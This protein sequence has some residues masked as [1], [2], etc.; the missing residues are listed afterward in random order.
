MNWWLFIAVLFG[1]QLFCLAVSSFVSKGLK[2][3]KDY[4][5]AGRTVRFFPLMMTLVATQVGG[6]L[7]LGA[8]Q[9]AYTYGWSVILY[10]LGQSLGFILLAAGIGRKM[11]ESGASTVA[12][13]CECA[14]G[15]R[16]LRQM[17]SILSIVS[18]FMIFVAQVIAS[19]KFMVSLGFDQL[20]IFLL[21]WA[22][23]IL[24]TVMGGLKAVIATD[25]VQAAFFIFVFIGALFFA[26]GGSFSDI[27][28]RST[29]V[30]FDA[31]PAPKMLGWL[32]MPLLFMAIEQD[33]GQRCF[34][35][36]SP[37]TVT[38]AAFAAA[39]VTIAICTIPVFF[40]VLAKTLDVP[41]EAGGS[42]FM[43]VI[44]T[45]TNPSIT[46]LVACAVLAAIISTADSLIN[47][48]SSNLTQDFNW[49]SNQGGG[50]IRTAQ[51][52]TTGI[53]LAGI[54]FSFYF[55]NIVD[56]LIQSY[57]LSIS[58]LFI[59]V[60]IALLKGRGSAIS[61]WISFSAGALAFFL[62]RIV[63]YEAPKE[64]ISIFFSGIGYLAGDWFFPK[65]KSKLG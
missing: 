37:K 16:K 43:T 40:G 50:N 15:S 26:E 42:V 13:L 24:Y 20:S 58:C 56:V 25:V 41:I 65:A 23:V 63:P 59:P 61:A 12:E 31:D 8:A 64:I 34:A 1:L 57:D 28:A 48:I 11:A 5:L 27:F 33:M 53:A 9:E 14:F 44:R 30:S 35:A 18:L 4:F 10:P 2:T 49:K 55:D 62:F 7:V 54:G 51:A 36:D 6:G 52:I 22:L 47:A 17:A 21:F 19:K 38:S 29:Q 32:I 45:V 60:M 46:A 39:L 3:N